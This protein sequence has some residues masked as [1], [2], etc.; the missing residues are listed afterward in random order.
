M[1]AGP[2]WARQAQTERHL[3]RLRLAA[4]LWELYRDQ[5]RARPVDARMV[6]Y[7][8]RVDPMRLIA[9]LRATG[10]RHDQPRADE[11]RSCALLAYYRR[12]N[13]EQTSADT[14]RA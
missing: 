2:W 8:A 9:Y 11:P 14:G 12:I 6:G 5:R 13:D 3:A 4:D 1:T 10:R 7:V